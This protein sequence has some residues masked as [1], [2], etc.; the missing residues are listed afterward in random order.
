MFM[1][2][3]TSMASWEKSHGLS[4][5]I[6]SRWDG[7][8]WDAYDAKLFGQA[9]LSTEKTLLFAIGERGAM[10]HMLVTHYLAPTHLI[11]GGVCKLYLT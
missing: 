7:K 11:G 9:M 10:R 5:C 6:G 4:T 3:L 8:A 1:F 2:L